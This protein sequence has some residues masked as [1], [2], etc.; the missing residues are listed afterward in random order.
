MTENSTELGDLE[1][2]VMQLV[3]AGGPLTSE[4]VREQLSRPLKES[5][6][7]TVLR[8][9]EDKGFVTHSVQGRTYVFEAAEARRAVAARAVRRIADWLCNGSVEE[10]LVGMVDTDMLD[11][12]ELQ[13]FAAK[14]AK[15]RQ[16]RG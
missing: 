6:V 10:V 3:W 8:R 1:R 13:Q 15:A 2:D 16:R 5:T 14:I 4:A 7:R 12:R 11:S 9:L